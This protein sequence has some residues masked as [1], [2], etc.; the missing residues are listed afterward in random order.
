MCPHREFDSEDDGWNT[1]EEIDIGA[2]ASG[3]GDV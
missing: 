1:D 2:D 3:D